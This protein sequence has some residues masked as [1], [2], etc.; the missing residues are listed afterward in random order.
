MAI[1]KT[2]GKVSAIV[3]L[4]RPPPRL[5][6]PPVLPSAHRFLGKPPP[7]EDALG[8]LDHLRVAA[9]VGGGVLPGEPELVRV[10][11]EDVLAATHLA[12]PVLVFPG[13]ADGGDVGQPRSVL[14]EALHL[15]AVAELPGAAGPL[16]D[17]KLEP[18]GPLA[19]FPV[20]VSG[21]RHACVGGPAGG[22]GG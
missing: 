2:P 18:G 19:V 3:R 22:P 11:P 21:A 6:R 7:L 12:L 14:R 5:L 20:A 13:T 1:R 16:Q 10:L 9:E 4:D 17:D 8:L 15:F